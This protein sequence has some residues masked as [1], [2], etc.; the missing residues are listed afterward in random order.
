MTGSIQPGSKTLRRFFE[1]QSL[2]LTL[3]NGD[4]ATL[5]EGQEVKISGN[6]TVAKRAA[7]DYPVGIVKIPGKSGERITVVTT[8]SADLAGVA[9]AGAALA[10]GQFVAPTGNKNAAGQPEYAVATAGQYVLAVVL[11]GGA[12]GSEVRLGV[13]RTPFKA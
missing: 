5:T 10:A 12:A 2:D 13:L 11:A 3:L 4:A 6:N 9:S 1:L 8:L 7:A